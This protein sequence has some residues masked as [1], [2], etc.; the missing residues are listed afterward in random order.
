MTVDEYL[1]IAAPRTGYRNPES[2]RFRCESVFKDVELAGRSVMEIGAG[3]GT[4]CFW[5]GFHGAQEVVGLEPDVDGSSEGDVQTFGAMIDQTG[6]GTIKLYKQT[7]QEYQ[8]PVEQ[9]DV[10]VSHNSMEHLDE[11]VVSRLRSDASARQVY[12]QIL[13]KVAR[14]MKPGAQF[15][16]CNQSMANFWPLIGRRN[17]FSP[18]VHWPLHP[19]PHTWKRLLLAN[20]FRDVKIDWPVRHRARLLGPVAAN[21]V[22]AFFTDSMFRITA[23]R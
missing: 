14:S 17:P 1:R 23:R 7:I 10:V 8:A 2:L 5:A 20:G 9:F 4:L 22:F 15:V 6:L 12:G 11:S 19:T 3:S 21:P 16:I 18:T 13:R